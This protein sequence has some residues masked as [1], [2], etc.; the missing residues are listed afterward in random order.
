[1]LWRTKRIEIPDDPKR[2]LNDYMILN[3]SS[4]ECFSYTQRR[5]PA[6]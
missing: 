2:L 6:F 1:M 4:K 5:R 3:D